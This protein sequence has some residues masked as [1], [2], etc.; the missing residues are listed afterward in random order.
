[1]RL[2]EAMLLVVLPLAHIL[3]ALRRCV[4]AL[5]MLLIIQPLPDVLPPVSVVEDPLPLPHVRVPIP[6]VVL[7]ILP[8]V[9]SLSMETPVLELAFLWDG[10]LA[11]HKHF[12]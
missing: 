12:H 3:I 1:M 9:Q 6:Y 5:A 10:H 4:L 7:A 8:P 11:L 2:P